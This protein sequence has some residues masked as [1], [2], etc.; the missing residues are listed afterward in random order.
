MII[1][2]RNED[3]LDEL[4]ESIIE[5]MQFHP[6]NDISRVLELALE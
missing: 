4:P 5:S 3:D 1:P 2:A 6:T